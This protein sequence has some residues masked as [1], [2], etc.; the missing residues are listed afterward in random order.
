MPL[1]ALD[2]QRASFLSSLEIFV[3]AYTYFWSAWLLL[4]THLLQLEVTNMFVLREY[5]TPLAVSRV[6]IA[7]VLLLIL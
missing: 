5:N 4:F 7:A 1:N 6:F 3:T 2:Q